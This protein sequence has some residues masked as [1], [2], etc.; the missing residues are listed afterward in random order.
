MTLR[1]RRI[2]FL[3]FVLCFFIF[4]YLIVLHTQGYQFNFKKNTFEK[5]GALILTYQPKEANVFLNDEFKLSTTIFDNF[6]RLTRLLPGEYKIKVSKS[7]YF[8][9]QKTLAIYPELTTFAQNIKLFKNK[10]LPIKFSQNLK[11]IKSTKNNDKILSVK[12]ENDFSSLNLLNLVNVQETTLATTTAEFV[13]FIPSFDNKK[14][15]YAIDR[16]LDKKRSSPEFY[17]YNLENFSQ[18][19][20]VLPAAVLWQ[21]IKLDKQ[22]NN[23]LYY[24][25][26]NKIIQLDLGNGNEKSI[27]EIVP[28]NLKINDF[29]IKG[30]DFYLIISTP[31]TNYLAKADRSALKQQLTNSFGLDGK[32]YRFI[33]SPNLLTL[34]DKTATKLIVVN[35]DLG[36]ILTA[37]AKDASWAEEKDNDKLLYYNDFEIIVYYQKENKKELISRFSQ[38]IGR[39]I[40][41]P[42]WNHL[43]FSSEE[44]IKIVEL[45]LRDK[46]NIVNYPVK[47]KINDLFINSNGD[48][49]YL[50][51]KK[52]T[53]LFNLY[54]IEIQ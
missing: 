53:G 28:S 34:L 50:T 39:I 26:K 20:V 38:P 4:T 44:E 37:T 23:F 7:N 10:I 5:T 6:V 40:W 19:R 2:I 35:D 22:N 9:W 3:F 51:L 24:V 36:E 54:Q 15:F 49:L 21:N 47:G 29:L 13:D 27:L 17:I 32:N 52:E 25:Q 41:Y 48:K 18:Q 46:I 30:N 14:I 45:D 42:D 31:E 12:G 33:D 8:D 11:L 43:I 1:T 16:H